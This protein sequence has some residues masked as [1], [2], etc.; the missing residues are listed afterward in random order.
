MRVE[1]RAARKSTAVFSFDTLYGFDP[2]PSY[3]VS[4]LAGPC[5]SDTRDIQISVFGACRRRIRHSSNSHP[6]AR[7]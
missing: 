2:V 5:K 6:R 7:V 3:A 1:K 4:C